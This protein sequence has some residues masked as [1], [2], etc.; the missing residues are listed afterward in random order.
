VR[1]FPAKI[2]SALRSDLDTLFVPRGSDQATATVLTS[3][4]TLIRN[5]GTQHFKLPNGVPKGDVW[6]VALQ[7][8]YT[9]VNAAALWPPAGESFY[10][11][12]GATAY[13]LFYTNQGLRCTAL[14]DGTWVVEIVMMSR[15]DAFADFTSVWDFWQQGT[16]KAGAVYNGTNQFDNATIDM[17]S[18]TTTLV[19]RKKLSVVTSDQTPSIALSN[20]TYCN[21]GAGGAVQITLP[22]SPTVGTFFTAFVSAAQYVKFLA[23]TGQTIIVNTTTSASAG[24]VRSNVVGSAITLVALSTTVWGAHPITGTWTV[25][26]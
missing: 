25:D 21:T 7:Q 2:K 1:S 17:T 4:V 26:T 13:I 23:N 16:F 9:P 22:A 20:T 18:G 19:H 24:Y 11:S 14:G 15:G 6:F 10:N 5:K 3:K 8:G 12:V